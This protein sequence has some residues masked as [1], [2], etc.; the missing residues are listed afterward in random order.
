MTAFIYAL[1]D[2]REPASIRYVGMTIHTG[3]PFD[4]VKDTR[5][6]K[7][8]SHLCSWINLLLRDGL[9]PAVSIVE[10]F[11]EVISRA[12]LGE[13][14]RHHI[15]RLREEGHDLTN[16]T[17]GG[18][19]CAAFKGQHHSPETRA[20][21][22]E[23]WKHRT[24]HAQSPE[25][26]IKIGNKNRGLRRSPE[27][28]AKYKASHKGHVPWNKG[29]QLVP[30]DSSLSTQYRRMTR[31]KRRYRKV[32]SEIVLEVRA[33]WPQ[34]TLRAIAKRLDI[35]ASSV[36]CIV[37]RQRWVENLSKI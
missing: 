22:S 18:D 34:E 1:A 5:K 11:N 4:H 19:G 23:A 6:G 32:T 36:Y 21:M 25:T 7:R 13:R 30:D 27:S 9:E 20:K 10:Q 16:M 29:K 26:R 2:P 14:E 3:R 28:I 24:Q 17:E 31:A 35:S 33:C 37:K 12:E 8:K 15:K